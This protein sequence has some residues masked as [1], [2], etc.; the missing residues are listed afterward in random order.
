[1]AT[2][3]GATEPYVF[4]SYASADRE[5]VL[6][7]VERFR[8]AG[9][10]VWFDQ[11]DIGGGTNYGL[12]I[13]EGIERCAAFVLLCSAASLASRNVKQEIQLAWKYQRPYLPLLLT[14]VAIPQDVEYWLEGWQW[15]EVMEK[16]DA[17]WLPAAL[18]ALRRIGVEASAPPVPDAAT[19]LAPFASPQTP[20]AEPPPL[21][22][23]ERERGLLRERVAAAL[24]GRGNVVFVGGEAGIGKTALTDTLAY[25]AAARGALVLTGRCFDLSETPPYGPWL[26]LFA[27]YPASP[28]LPPLPAA[29]AERGTVGAVGSQMA[30][31]VQVQDFLAALAGQQPVMLLLDDLH[32]A[33]AATL[34]LVRFL[35]R[36]IVALPVLLVATYRPERITTNRALAQILPTL[37]RDASATRLDLRPLTAEEVRHLVTGRYAL[38]ER[39]TARLV[40]YLHE[41]AEGN[42]FFAGELLATLAEEGVLHE[43]DGH[44][45]LGDLAQVRVPLLLRQVIEERLERLGD[46]AKAHLALA[47]VIGQEIPLALWMAV[48][49]IGE[50]DLFDLIEQAAAARVLAETPDGDGARFTHALIR[51]ALYEGIPAMRR[52]R[53]HRQV[54]DAV[55][56]LPDPDPDIVAFH[57]Q[58]AGDDRAAAWLVTAAKRAERACAFA[59]AVTRFDEAL[60]LLAQAKDRAARGDVLIRL[61]RWLRNADTRRSIG[62]SG[63]AL[64]IAEESGDP[65]LA[66]AALYRRGSV[67]GYAG[68]Y[69]QGLADLEAAKDVFAAL[70]GEQRDRRAH[71]DSMNI[72]MSE[73]L[74]A[75]ANTLQVMGR[76]DE[77]LRSLGR[78][79]DQVDPVALPS[80]GS[81]RTALCVIDAVMGRPV[82]ARLLSASQ[83]DLLRA[84]REYVMIAQATEYEL[85]E[86]VLP[87]QADRLDER[88]QLADEAED[89]ARQA[90]DLTLD[91]S[92][93]TARVGLLVVEGQ[94]DEARALLEA[95]HRAGGLPG[96]RLAELRF[97]GQ[98]A[99][100]QGEAERA[101][102]LIRETLTDGPE[103]E[104]GDVYFV[105]GCAFQRL[106]ADLALDASDLQSA[107]AWLEAHDRWMAWSGAVLGHAEGAAGWARYHRAAGDAERA[108][109]HGRRALTHATEPRQPLAL[110]AAHRLLSAL[111]TDAG[112][113]ADAETHLTASLALADA[114]HA[115]YERALTLLA[116]AEL[117]AAMGARDT[118]RTLLD[119]IRAICTP[120]GAQPALTRAEALASRL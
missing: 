99:R 70:S 53:M 38:P 43:R 28:A 30:L 48:G 41:R 34:D 25:D 13:A 14:P 95:A 8:Q 82:E 22:G 97:L 33:D 76:Y 65:V 20:L 109:E 103:S 24:A 78:A 52:R 31:F 81:G 10:A 116:T 118:A 45:S 57:F 44:W 27:R 46:G 115:P 21:F 64:R 51:A 96:W 42:P 114:C 74:G 98:L 86:I 106:A 84:R 56:A 88:T 17:D 50:D 47:A 71:L 16:P 37:L 120:L 6:P 11:A 9:I 26:D 93:R 12:E 19:P 117:R 91:F 75:I 111:D 29:F 113:F 7:V 59:T 61:A 69:R 101:W 108:Y 62:Y 79:P 73:I 4:I 94:W 63:E 35:M 90:V 5:R 92:P 102:S 40:T 67:S 83:R 105:N 49:A 3:T 107:K 2:Q 72:D 68:N 89:A 60:P 100:V 87:Y 54:G 80:L 55:A 66:L 77:A 85:S 23:R 112:R 36:A 39:E 32:W 15:V 18:A 104:P 110:L 1:M 119:E 58:Q